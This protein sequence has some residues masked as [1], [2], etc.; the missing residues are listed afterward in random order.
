MRDRMRRARRIKFSSGFNSFTM[1]ED[2]AGELTPLERQMLR[3]RESVP[4]LDRIKEF[5]DKRSL[6]SLPKSALGKAITY[7]WNQW[8]AL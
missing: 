1:S 3:Q 8:A 5:L 2:R 7:A 4:I 6:R